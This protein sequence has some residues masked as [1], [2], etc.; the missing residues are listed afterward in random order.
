[1]DIRSSIR[2]I[3]KG[4]TFCLQILK[5][6]KVGAGGAYV[7]WNSQSASK[8][9]AGA[10][11]PSKH[12]LHISEKLNALVLDKSLY[13][14]SKLLCYHLTIPAM[15]ICVSTC[16][17][18]FQTD[19]EQEQTIISNYDPDNPELTLQGIFASNKEIRIWGGG[20]GD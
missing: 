16:M 12:V 17:S 5:D 18:T 1:M 3:S 7:T 2:T 19:C 20:G 4:E 10:I 14:G 13:K 9:N 8:K 15:F 11:H 6:L